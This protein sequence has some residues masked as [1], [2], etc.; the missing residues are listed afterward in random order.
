MRLLKIS[1]R[2]ELSF[3]DYLTTDIPPYAILSHTWGTDQEE[4]TFKDFIDGRAKNKEGYTKIQFCADQARKDGLRHFWI[5]TCCIDKTDPAEL[6]EA[7]VSMFRWYASAARCYVFLDSVTACKRDSVGNTQIWEA[8]RNSRWFTR[9]WTLQE[10]LAPKRVGFYSRDRVFLGDKDTLKH[11]IH[12]I[13]GIPIAALHGSPLADFTPEERMR[14]FFSPRDETTGRSGI[15]TYGRRL[16]GIWQSIVAS[17]SRDVVRD[18]GPTSTPTAEATLLDRRKTMLASLGFEQMDSRRSTIRTA[19]ST[20]CQWLLRHPDYLDWIDPQKIHE[21]CGFLW[22]NGK[23]GAGKSTLVKFAHASADRA[24]PESEIILSFFFNARGDELEKSTVGMYRALLFQLLTTMPDLQDLL[25]DV[26]HVTGQSGSPVC[27]VE[28]LCELLSAA[29]ARL[30]HRQLKCFIDAL[31]ECDEQQVQDMIA[32]FEELGQATL[33]HGSQL[34]ICFASRHYP[35]IN[36]RSGRQLTLEYEDGHAEDLEKYVQSHLRAGKGKVIEEV[37]TQIRDKANG[38]FLWVVLVV[39][40]LNEEFKRGRIFALQKKLREIPAKLSDL[41]KDILTKDCTNMDDLLLCLQW[42]LFAERPLRREEFYFAMLAGLESESEYMT[43]WNSEDI[44]TDDMNRFV[45]NSSKGLAE[46]TRSK[47]PTVQFIHESVRDYLIKEKGLHVLWPDLGDGSHFLGESHQRLKGCCLKYISIDVGPH[48]GNI[49]DSLPKASTPDA[50]LLR[51]SATECYPFLEYAVRKVLYHADKAQA[52]GVDQGDFIRTFPFANWIWT[53]NLLETHEVRRHT[54]NVSFLYILAENNLASLTRIHRS[55]L[56]CFDVEAERYGLPL[57]AALATGSD[58]CVRALLVVQAETHPP[59]SLFR[60]LCEEYCRYGNRRAV[61]A[62]DFAFSQRRGP[63]TSLA[64]QGNDILLALLCASDKLIIE[65]TGHDGRTPLSWVAG[66]GHE[67]VVRLLVEKGAKLESQ[68]KYN[69]T[70][71]SWAAEKGHGA[72]GA[73][74]EPKDNSGRTPLSWAADRGHE[75]VVRLLVEKGANLELNDKDGWTP[76]ST[77]V[78][79]GHG[80]VVRLPVEKGADLNPKDKDGR[81]PLSRAVQMR[82]VEVVR[83][84]VDKGADLEPKDNSGRTPLSWAAD[85][86]H[87]EVVRLLV[88]KGAE[89]EPKDKDG[90]TLLP[91]RDFNLDFSSLENSD[92]LENFDFDRVLHTSNEDTFDFD[93]AMGIGEDLGVDTTNSCDM[94][95]TRLRYVDLVDVQHVPASDSRVCIT[96]VFH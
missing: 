81:T 24:R 83:L 27:T 77:A 64:E 76:L 93:Q 86:G 75:A 92:V 66:I 85:R 82:H 28:T 31:D 53:D 39:P 74:L 88:D 9:G 29:T 80:A 46:L 51:Q 90:R 96:K 48:L 26:S 95:K 30:G 40:M 59:T 16:E 10:L 25:D 58:E 73:D 68:D 72:V 87:E 89:L 21:H 65:A 44:T 17:D 33:N 20:T 62:R 50:A 7:I 34:Y 45:L 49:G 60:N 42:I 61:L 36:I 57:F 94:E 18:T 63:L 11:V 56:S 54:P 2:G 19:Y 52:T 38:V 8:F 79:K 32:F 47:S 35:T 84:L 37:R 43:A 22:I 41:F 78:E 4:V 5:D 91:R 23:P 71:L 1:D 3:T 12:E 69:R 15:L 14:W 55:N 67:A 13:T 70:P 6:S